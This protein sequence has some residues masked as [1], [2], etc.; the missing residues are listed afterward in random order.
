MSLTVLIIALI[1]LIVL[2]AISVQRRM[3]RIEELCRNAMSQIGVQ[4]N[5]RW[6]ALKAL[7][8]L[9]KSYSEHEYKALTDIIAQRKNIGPTSTPEQ[10]KEQEKIMS[11]AMAVVN[12]VSE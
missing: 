8:E 11:N 9:T 6:D 5:S 10:V 7:A 3:V 4:Q 12:A 1:V 2:W